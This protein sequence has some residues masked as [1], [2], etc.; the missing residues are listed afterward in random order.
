MA[1]LAAAGVVAEVAV[2]VE[3]AEIICREDKGELR[4]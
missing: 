4:F 2:A 1:G 3:P